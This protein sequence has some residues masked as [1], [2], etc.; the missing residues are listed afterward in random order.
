MEILWMINGAQKKKKKKRGR[1]RRRWLNSVMDKIVNSSCFLSVVWRVNRLMC[2][3]RQAMY[4]WPA[5]EFGF[6]TL[7]FA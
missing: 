5:F 1:K 2:L 6:Q 4:I 3:G 7:N